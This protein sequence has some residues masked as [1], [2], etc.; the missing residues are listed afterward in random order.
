VY[1]LPVLGAPTN[2]TLQAAGDREL[3]EE[4]MKLPCRPIVCV[5]LIV[6]GAAVFGHLSV[7]SPIVLAGTKLQ[8]GESPATSVITITQCGTKITTPGIYTATLQGCTSD[9]IDINTSDV[10]LQNFYL[11]STCSGGCSPNQVGIL[12]SDPAGGTLRNVKI[13][14]GAVGDFTTSVTFVGVEHSQ[15]TGV[16]MG[17]YATTC[18]VLNS[19]TQ[20]DTSHDNMFT[21]NILGG[22]GVAVEGNSI[23][24]SKFIA[25]TCTGYSNVMGI[26]GFQILNGTG[27]MFAG[28]ACG[29]QGIGIQLSGTGSNGV[30]GNKFLGN[31]LTGNSTGIFVGAGADGNIFR[32]NYFYNSVGLDIDDENPN[33]G[34]DKWSR[35]VFK[36]ANQSCVH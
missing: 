25:N 19:D 16:G 30:T 7:L 23:Y 26:V 17:S 34:T 22:C 32:A 1:D 27:N 3:L 12:V 9:G 11:G 18:L 33:C 29:N 10:T 5:L 24:T 8:P 13:L 28:N 14:G 21:A 2:V 15:V 6:L 31:Q 36:A 4:C 35:N 20:G